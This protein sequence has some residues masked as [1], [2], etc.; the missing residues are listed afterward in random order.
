MVTIYG[1]YVPSKKFYS[2]V[3]FPYIWNF[4]VKNC[5]C[6]ALEA[7]KLPKQGRQDWWDEQTAF[8]SLIE[9]RR[10]AMKE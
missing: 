3:I 8:A 2:Y 4:Q 5:N 9:E 10:T 7:L 1:K 6:R